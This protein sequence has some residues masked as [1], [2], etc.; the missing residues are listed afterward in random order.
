MQA[1]MALVDYPVSVGIWLCIQNPT[2]SGVPEAKVCAELNIMMVD[3]LGDKI[4]SSSWLIAAA[5]G[6]EKEIKK[7]PNQW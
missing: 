5:A 7:D 3:A 2:L 6:K 4:N 1:F